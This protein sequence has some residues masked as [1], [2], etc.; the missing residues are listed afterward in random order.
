MHGNFDVVIPPLIPVSDSSMAWPTSPCHTWRIS[1]LSVAF[2][3]LKQQTVRVQIS[4]WPLE[5]F[6]HPAR[7][8]AL[9]GLP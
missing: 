8:Q 2:L 4:T 9:T 1:L 5:R 6:G 3:D 7:L